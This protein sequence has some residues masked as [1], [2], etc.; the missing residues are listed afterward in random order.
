MTI[1]VEKGKTDQLR[2]GDEVV[3]AQSGVRPGLKEYLGRF[4]IDPQSSV[5][6]MRQLVKTKSPYKLVKK[7]KPIS[8]STLRDQ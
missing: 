7:D 4:N 3:A 6:T 5:L 8:Y 1:K 2:E